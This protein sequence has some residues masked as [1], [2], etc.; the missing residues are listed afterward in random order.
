MQLKPAKSDKSHEDLMNMLTKTNMNELGITLFQTHRELLCFAACLGYAI[1]ERSKLSSVG[2]DI[3]MAEF[4]SN[5]SESYINLIALVETNN[6]DILKEKNP[7][8]VENDRNLIFDEYANAGLN[9]IKSWIKAV[10]S[11]EFHTAII[12]GLLTEK[13]IGRPKSN[14]DEVH[15]DFRN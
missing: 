8:T 10:D 13:F 7:N 2:I 6:I 5:N 3:G 12:S 1:S 11:S 9:K 15:V 14:D 4:K